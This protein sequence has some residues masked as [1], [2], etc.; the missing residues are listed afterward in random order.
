MLSVGSTDTFVLLKKIA[1][2]SYVVHTVRLMTARY[3]YIALK[4][5]QIFQDIT[6]ER[7]RG[8]AR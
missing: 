5:Q 1:T 2:D 8:G 6:S 7:D 3:R 4:L